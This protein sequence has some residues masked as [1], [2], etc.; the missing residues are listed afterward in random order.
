MRFC[1]LLIFLLGHLAGNVAGQAPSIDDIPF[2]EDLP[3]VESQPEP[4]DIPEAP[5]EQ[6]G[7][8]EVPAQAQSPAD[9]SNVTVTQPPIPDPFDTEALVTWDEFFARGGIMMYPLTALS[10]IAILLVVFYFLTIRGGTVVSDSFMNQAEAL[11]RKQDYLGLL[12]TCNRSNESVA[13]VTQKSLDFATRNPTSAFTEVR[14]VAE[15][16][17]TRQAGL[18]TQRISYLG[19]IGS[20]APMVGLLGTVI[21][22]IKSFNEISRQSVG[23][24]NMELAGGVSEALITTAAGLVIGIPALVF[25]SIFRG[26]VQKYIAELEAAT[27]HLMALLSAQYQTATHRS[28]ARAARDASTF[29]DFD[30]DED[31]SERDLAQR[32]RDPRGV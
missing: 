29:N 5:D 8:Q 30:P 4:T 10:F 32:R 7:N 21:G 2:I 14:E 25:Y 13:K 31:L 20:I 15:A 27:T 17:G 19:D 28:S 16:E 9:E 1:I 24:R 22:M 3:E 18:L 26:R 12:A 23:A 11:L 6:A